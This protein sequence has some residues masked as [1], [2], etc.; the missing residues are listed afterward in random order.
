MVPLMFSMMSI[1][2]E[3]KSV[4]NLCMLPIS[5][6]Q[7]IKGKL[8]PTWTIAFAAT[9]AMVILSSIIAPSGSFLAF[10]SIFS[11][12]FVI[13]A[14]GFIGLGIASRHP[15]Y[16]TSG[17]RGF[18]VTFTGFLTGFLIGG[19]AALAIFTPTL[20]RL[21]F[22]ASGLSQVSIAAAYQSYMA[23]IIIGASICL[24]A[25]LYCKSGITRFLSN[26]PQ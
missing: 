7:L 18:Y 17:Q 9:V 20:L 24:V 21:S 26:V 5:P 19:A 13:A 23:T 11:S 4:I 15:D 1:G 14:E 10:S 3:G 2:Q 16:Q 8:L 6:R 25:Y 22:G 12:I